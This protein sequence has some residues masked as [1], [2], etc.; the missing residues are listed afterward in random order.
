MCVQIHTFGLLTSVCSD[1]HV[2]P[3]DVSGVRFQIFIVSYII[4][5]GIMMMNVVIA[6]FLQVLFPSVCFSSLLS[7]QVLEGP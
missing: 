3:A 5:V 2:S 4:I 1:V 7:L 6:V